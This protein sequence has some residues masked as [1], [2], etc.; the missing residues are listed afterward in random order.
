[1]AIDNAG[2]IHSFWDGSYSLGVVRLATG[3]TAKTIAKHPSQSVLYVNTMKVDSVKSEATTLVPITMKLPL[4]DDK[5][6]RKVAETST[7]AR[8]LVWYT[9]RT[10]KEMRKAWFGGDGSDGAR[11]ANASWVRSFHERQAQF[12]RMLCVIT[13]AFI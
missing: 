4:M 11:E 1:M 7:T 12:G 8:E 9:M 5:M 3:Y 2:Q 6:T 13:P 10:V